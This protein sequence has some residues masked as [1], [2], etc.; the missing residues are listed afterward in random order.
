MTEMGSLLFGCNCKLNVT[1]WSGLVVAVR[2]KIGVA[3]AKPASV[4]GQPSWAA[5]DWPSR[6]AALQADPSFHALA[7]FREPGHRGHLLGA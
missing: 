7:R 2:E 5:A 6:R 4:V 3:S 1:E